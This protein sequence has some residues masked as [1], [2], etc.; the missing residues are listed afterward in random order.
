MVIDSA[1]ERGL[2]DKPLDPDAVVDFSI[3]KALRF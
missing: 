3:T 2:T 1:L